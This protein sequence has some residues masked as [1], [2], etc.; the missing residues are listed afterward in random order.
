MAEDKLLKR[1]PVDADARPSSLSEL[2][3]PTAFEERLKLA[4]ARRAVALAQRAATG[5]PL[6]PRIPALHRTDA[7]SRGGDPLVVPGFAVPP[8]AVPRRDAEAGAAPGGSAGSG[9]GQG[10][11]IG[12]RGGLP[13][14][15]RL[16]AWITVGLARLAAPRAFLSRLPALPRRG[17]APIIASF[18]V[19]GFGVGALALALVPG[20]SSVPHAA[21]QVA[22]AV[23][24]PASP[25]A[26]VAG[27]AATPELPAVSPV[28][29]VPIDQGPLPAQVP[30]PD[31][32][33][34][35]VP[36]E[37]VVETVVPLPPRLPG[38][39]NPRPRSFGV[40]AA[41][42]AAPEVVTTDAA[43]MSSGLDLSGI[44][45]FVHFPPSVGATARAATVSA[46]KADGY[47]TVE[48][49]RANA[50][51][52]TTNVRYF[53]AEDAEAARQ[54]AASLGEGAVAR[55]FTDLSPPPRRGR[56]EVWMQGAAPQPSASE[57]ILQIL[58]AR[59]QQN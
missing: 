26:P 40:T 49:I 6:G 47:P 16:G 51:I 35:A 39:P 23:A 12:P 48:P 25:A 57:A 21:P 31:G 55:D 13:P 44:R 17:R 50:S 11:W 9:A 2:F 3:D 30:G 14:V 45:V 42:G 34:S 1:V 18:V 24:A 22:G 7:G 10:G 32:P 33:S 28:P 29:P 36:D 27:A 53:H 54:L 59:G 4:R 38:G 20:G 52:D 15:A 43:A 46:L 58:Q 41:I 19:V 37:Q 56:L 8:R 5:M